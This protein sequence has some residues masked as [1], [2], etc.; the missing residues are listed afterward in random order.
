MQEFIEIKVLVLKH[1]LVGIFPKQNLYIFA[2]DF[3]QIRA[4]RSEDNIPS[5]T[6]TFTVSRRW[7][8]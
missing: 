4:A 1:F 2:I 3:C 6:Y 5:S 7:V 8:S